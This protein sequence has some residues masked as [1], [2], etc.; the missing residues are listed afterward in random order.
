MKAAWLLLGLLATGAARAEG[1]IIQGLLV[2]NTISR[3]GHEFYR[4]F[5]DR[6]TDTTELDFNLVVRERPSARWGSLVW[7]EYEQRLLYRQFIPPG[8]SDLKEAAYAAAD[9]VR[10]GITRQRLENLLQDNFDM[11]KDEL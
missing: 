7:V 3:F 6:L 4:Q 11:E 1:D 2:D 8:N 10:E 5:A 9:H